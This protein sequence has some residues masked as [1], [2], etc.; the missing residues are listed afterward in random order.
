MSVYHFYMFDAY[1]SSDGHWAKP[2][3][4][5]C[6]FIGAW[7][8]AQISSDGNWAKPKTQDIRLFAHVLKRKTSYN[9]D[10]AKP[11]N[12]GCQSITF[13]R[14]TRKFRLMA[15]GQSR[16]N[17]GCQS[18]FTSFSAYISCDGDWAKPK[19]QDVG[20]VCTRFETKTS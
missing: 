18:R 5:G 20:L 12:P 4:T 11:K 14:L 16:K 9:G 6:Q 13:T 2:K 7:F 8:S 19:T 1:F 3:N 10:W 15:T 17:P